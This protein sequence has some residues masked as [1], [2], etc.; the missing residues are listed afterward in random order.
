MYGMTNSGKVFANELTDWSIDEAGFNHSKCQISVYYNY[1]P[2]CS[3]LVVLSYVYDCVCWYK[4]EELGK[5]FVNT[6]GKIFHVNFLGYAHWFM[7]IGISQLRDHS[8]SVNQSRY[9]IC[10]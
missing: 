1:A 9:A 5:W 8:I 3:K 2:D 4:Y 6:L 10:Y 7:S